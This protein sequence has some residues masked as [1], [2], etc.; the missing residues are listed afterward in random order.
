M[1]NVS[2]INNQQNN[3]I[4][5]VPFGK[6]DLTKLT[7]NECKIILKKCFNS[8]PA[9]VEKLHFDK[10]HT[11]NHNIYISNMRDDFVLVYDGKIWKLKNR[12]EIEKGEKRN[13]GIY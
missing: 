13:F 3:Y 4:N 8:V 2:F 7:D 11:E 9:L 6:E 10:D 5:I 12:T 1:K